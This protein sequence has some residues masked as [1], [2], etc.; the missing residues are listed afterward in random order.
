VSANEGKWQII[1]IDFDR[2]SIFETDR[3]SHEAQALGEVEGEVRWGKKGR[4]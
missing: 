4:E 1:T 3:G 2:V